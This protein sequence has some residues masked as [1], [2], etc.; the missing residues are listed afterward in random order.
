[1]GWEYSVNILTGIN[2]KKK[3]IC[4]FLKKTLCFRG[5]KIHSKTIIFLTMLTEKLLEYSMYKEMETEKVGSQIKDK[6]KHVRVYNL[7]NTKPK[8]ICS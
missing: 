3:Y 2:V 4:L 6:G 5:H 7:S 1:M 8:E